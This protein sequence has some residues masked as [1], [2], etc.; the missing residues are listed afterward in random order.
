MSIKSQCETCGWTTRRNI[1]N[2]SRPCPKCGGRVSVHEDDRDTAVIMVV[3]IV[4]G[5][6]GIA[7]LFSALGIGK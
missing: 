3:V 6:I 2:V 4:A 1:E 5:M 7:V